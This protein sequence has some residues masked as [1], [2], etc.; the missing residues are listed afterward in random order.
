MK[1]NY[2]KAILLGLGYFGISAAWATYNAFTPILLSGRFHL[3]PASIGAFLALD[4][5]AALLIQPA[6][7]AWSDRVRT[8]IGRRMPF[9]LVGAPI[10]AAVFGF[11]PVTTTFALFILCGLTFLLSMAFWRAPFFT[12]LPDTT[13]SQYR[14]QANG[15][16][17]SIGVMGA[18]LAFLGGSQLHSR[19][20]AYPFWMSSSLLVV[21]VAPLVLFLREAKAPEAKTEA[22]P[23]I[24]RTVGEAWRDPD[25]SVLRI[26]FAIL[27]VFIAN[28]ALDAFVTL[29]SVNHLGLTAIDG[30]RLMGQFTVLFI[31]FAIPA[32]FIGGHIGRRSS[33]CCG[34]AIMAFCTVAQ[35]LL[36]V[37]L[38]T[39]P[40]GRLPVL[41]VVPIIGLTMM[42][43]GAGWSLVHTNSI[44][45]V[46]DMTTPG[47]VG[48]YIGLYYLFSTVGAIVGPIINGWIIELSGM[49]YS[50]TMLAGPFFLLLALGVMLGVRRGEA[51]L[52]QQPA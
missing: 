39:H 35:F 20:P 32:G 26:L 43:T 28:N 1:F 38:L 45:M 36:P 17:N 18:M 2:S 5:I 42:L 51:V 19:N 7:G 30:A 40:V 25:K 46:V 16:I 29:Y 9:I 31:L 49:D 8:P 37:P 50:M 47:K 14:S 10:G 13:P 52:L 41:G 44:P 15:I 11:I 24:W 6:V 22:R 34:I 48:T 21:T 27:L 23:G 33:I 3:G 12:L 4:N